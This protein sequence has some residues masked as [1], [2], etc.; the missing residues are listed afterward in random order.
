MTV[1][2]EVERVEGVDLYCRYPRQ[3]EPQGCHVELDCESRRLRAA[4][5][6]EIGNAV[7]MRVYHQRAL[8]WGIP[9]MK[10]DAANVLLASI[11]PLAERVVAGYSCEWDGSNHVGRY[12]DDA[13]GACDEIESLCEMVG[14]DER[15]VVWDAAEWFDALGGWARQAAELGVRPDTSDETLSALEQQLQAEACTEGVD[16]IEGLDDFLAELRDL[17]RAAYED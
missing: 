16:M 7:P 17:V 9:A 12:S 6:V 4:F 10:A 8:R 13:E 15:L 5:D 3:T 11:V 14:E 2:I 1:K